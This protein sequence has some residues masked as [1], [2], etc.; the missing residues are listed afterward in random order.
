MYFIKFILIDQQSTSLQV[1]DCFNNIQIRKIFLV[2]NQK[3][4]TFW[5]K[6]ATTS[7]T[8]SITV[9]I[10]KQIDC[11]K[12]HRQNLS[13]K[14]RVKQKKRYKSE[15][16]CPEVCFIGININVFLPLLVSLLRL[17][18]VWA[19]PWVGLTWWP[20]SATITR[21]IH[22][23]IHHSLHTIMHDLIISLLSFL[24]KKFVFQLFFLS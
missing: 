12:L 15:T 22:I 13:H 3:G 8:C 14:M 10:S 19:S 9:N 6:F 21:F 7:G 5:E 16:P 18:S 11:F 24:A 17:P 1:F 2:N 4:S 23:E 20:L